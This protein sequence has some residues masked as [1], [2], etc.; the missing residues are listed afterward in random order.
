MCHRNGFRST[1][2]SRSP[3]TLRAS[4]SHLGTYRTRLSCQNRESLAHMPKLLMESLRAACRL[5]L[6]TTYSRTTLHA[7]APCH[8]AMNSAV[9]DAVPSLKVSFPIM[10]SRP[11]TVPNE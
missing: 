9:I 4:A 2:S 11:S 3:I 7:L 10:E 5:L 8:T 6:G 1:R